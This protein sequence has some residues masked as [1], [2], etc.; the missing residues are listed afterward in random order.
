MFTFENIMWT[1][2]I[3][4][5]NINKTIIY[6]FITLQKKISGEQRGEAV[7]ENIKQSDL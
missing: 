1:T 4:Y 7:Y 3:S 6:Y 2:G 5:N